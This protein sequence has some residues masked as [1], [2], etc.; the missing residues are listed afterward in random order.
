MVSS[1]ENKGDP[2]DDIR[3]C[4]FARHVVCRV[5]QDIKYWQ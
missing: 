4:K 3:P 5:M 1:R 2:S